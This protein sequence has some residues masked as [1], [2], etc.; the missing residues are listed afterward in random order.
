MREH[1]LARQ[2]DCDVLEALALLSRH[3]RAYPR[4]W[5]WSDGAVDVA[6]QTGRIAT[7]FGWPLLVGA[8]TNPRGVRNFPVQGN[9]AEMMRLAAC[10]TVAAGV[11]LVATIHD[12]LVI[13]ANGSDLEDA[14]RATQAAMDRASS[15]VLGGFVLRTEVKYIRHPD[16]FRDPRGG[17][18]NTVQRLLGD[19]EGCPIGA[20]LARRVS[21]H[22]TGGC[23]KTFHLP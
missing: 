3:R 5:A 19:A 18:W 22:G 10:V 1:T 4:F 12:A 21:Q 13:E 14:V 9:A 15:I 20:R 11:E 2:L 17:L 23:S 16:R 7:V 8:R 6:M